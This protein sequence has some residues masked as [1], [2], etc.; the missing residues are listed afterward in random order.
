M[1]MPGSVQTSGA[2]LIWGEVWRCL[3]AVA[4]SAMSLAMYLDPDFDQL[5]PHPVF[6]LEAACLPVAL[7]L[8]L[9]RRRWPLAVALALSVLASFSYTAGGAELIALVSLA[10]HR[11]WGQ[12]GVA[13]AA[14]VASGQISSILYPTDVAAA[15]PE[16]VGLLGP[17]TGLA[18]TLAGVVYSALMTCL[19]MAVGVAIGSRRDLNRSLRERAELNERA[20]AAREEQARAAE[21]TRIA[22]EMHDVIAQLIAAVVGDSRRAQATARLARLTDKELEVA[23]GVAQGAS[24]A[25]I[26]EQSHMSLSTVKTHIAHA[27]EKLGADNRVQVAIIVHEAGA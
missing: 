22:R 21:R 12:M 26:A 1:T 3:V 11:R 23:K 17:Y 14:T 13:V 24:N 2:R 10:T 25:D 19:L 4:I 6:W 8:L 16:V 5:G 18:L 7:G 9:L 27:M 15:I 20:Q